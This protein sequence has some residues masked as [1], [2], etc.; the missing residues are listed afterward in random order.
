MSKRSISISVDRPDY[1]VTLAR[2]VAFIYL[3]SAAATRGEK[4]LEQ[5]RP[6]GLP[7]CLS[8]KKIRMSVRMR[9]SKVRRMSGPFRKVRLVSPIEMSSLQGTEVVVHKQKDLRVCAACRERRMSRLPEPR[10]YQT[11]LHSTDL[12]WAPPTAR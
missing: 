9:R 12:T 2:L 1:A 4:T 11:L 7:E 5:D 6:K 3:K 10:N 8:T